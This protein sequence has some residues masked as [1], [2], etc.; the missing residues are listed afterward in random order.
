MIISISLSINST[1]KTE[2]DIFSGVSSFHTWLE[3]GFLTRSRDR[4]MI[5]LEC[6]LWLH[7]ISNR[8]THPH[9]ISHT[10]T[11]IY[12]YT[13]ASTRTS[14]IY[15]WQNR[16][17]MERNLRT[18]KVWQNIKQLKKGH[19]KLFAD[20]MEKIFLNKYKNIQSKKKEFELSK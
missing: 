14:L 9:N 13:S 12:V 1:T 20:W 11:Y 3:W 4:L 10:Q 7:A 6:L 19:H 16:L 2:I 5:W 18:D 8:N 15:Y 17:F